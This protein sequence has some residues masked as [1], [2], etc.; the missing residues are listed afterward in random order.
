MS[1]PK[2][3]PELITRLLNLAEFME[4]VDKPLPIEHHTLGDYAM[5]N[6]INAKALH[7][8]ELEFFAQASE[9]VLED[10]IEI[11][12]KLQ[13]HDAATGAL[14]LASEC[15]GS[16][17]L[18]EWH[19][20]LGQW[21]DA[22]HRYD[23]ELE[24]D[25]ENLASRMGVMRC[26]HALGHWDALSKWMEDFWPNAT[27]EQ[28]MTVAPMAAATSWHLEEWDAMEGFLSVLK[29]NSP[30]KAF[31]KSIISVRQNQFPKALLNIDRAR[32]LLVNELKSI[33]GMDHERTY[34][35]V[36]RLRAFRL[37]IKP[38]GIWCAHKYCRSWKRL[39]SISN[40]LTNPID[41]RPYGKP[42]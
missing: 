12:S 37:F 8:K 21:D 25:P 7:Y 6:N 34:K 38:I 31:Y 27:G 13:Q 14:F 33:G 10:L 3:A 41:K 39:F 9:G 5:N 1:A 22:Q 16:G 20:R 15:Y 4:H 2:I 35:S 17:K 24:R 29:G 18:E 40:M 30:D 11:N 32:D 23:A 42:G 28:R 26:Y 19:E 36:S